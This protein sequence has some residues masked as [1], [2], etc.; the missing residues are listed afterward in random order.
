MLGSHLSVAGGL[1]NALREAKA[2]GMDCVQIFTRNQRQWTAPPLRDDEIAQWRAGLQALGWD[3]DEA[4]RVV[5]HNSYLVNVASPDPELWEKSLRAQRAELERCEALGVPAC[6]MHPGSHMGTPKPRQAVGSPPAGDPTRDE[7]A[8]LK[9]IVKALDRIHRELPGY[10]T[11]TLLET[12]AGAGTVLGY[13]FAHLAWIRARVKA[14]ERIGF[15][16][17]TC[18]AHVAGYD[19]TTEAAATATWQRWREVCG[20]TTLRAMHLN[21]SVGPLGS[22]LD[23]HAHIGHGTC[24]MACFRSVMNDP[25]LSCVPK[26][27]ETPKG[28]DE[29][30]TA[31]DTV[32]MRHLRRLVTAASGSR[33]AIG[34]ED[35]AGVKSPKGAAKSARLVVNSPAPRPKRR[36]SSTD[37]G[38]KRSKRPLP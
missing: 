12:T 24:G 3:D 31:W 33:S 27:L 13:D 14:P 29:R 21:D 9:R 30:G 19:M 22:R 20:P 5:S 2:L 28:E 34:T 23:R 36:Q 6:V 16:F 10:R 25:E 7:L 11:L 15:C 8:G 35:P 4:C 1:V 38:G 37:S 26:V 18:H 32:N 17:D